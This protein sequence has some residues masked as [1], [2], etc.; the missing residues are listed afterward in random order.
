M[1]EDL[2]F[3][4]ENMNEIMHRL[5]KGLPRCSV[6]K[7]DMTDSS[8]QVFRANKNVCIVIDEYLDKKIEPRFP[9]IFDKDRMRHSVGDN[10]S[11]V[12]Y[13]Q[14]HT[15]T[16]VTSVGYSTRYTEFYE[17]RAVEM[18]VSHVPFALVM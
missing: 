16:G 4:N 10:V 1:S 11:V 8:I 3:Y 6:T 18:T 12:G 7:V 13:S 17:G 2:A 5:R 15:I 14:V 9:P